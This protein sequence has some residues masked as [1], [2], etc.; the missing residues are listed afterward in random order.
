MKTLHMTDYVNLGC[1]MAKVANEFVEMWINTSGQPCN[2]CDLTK[3]CEV[4][5][6]GLRH[7]VGQDS[8]LQEPA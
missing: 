8:G 1:S 5:N 4:Y 2:R 6:G 3:T 7:H